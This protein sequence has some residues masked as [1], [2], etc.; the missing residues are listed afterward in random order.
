M[1]ENK[2]EF[3]KTARE[4][5]N[6]LVRVLDYIIDEGIPENR[7][8]GK[9]NVQCAWFR[10]FCKK[11]IDFYQSDKVVQFTEE[12]WEPSWQERFFTALLG[13]NHPVFADIDEEYFSKVCEKYVSVREGKV[14]RMYYIDGLILQEIGN[15]MG[16]TR[17]RI[18]QIL[19]LGLRKLRAPGPRNAL[20]YGGER[21]EIISELHTAQAEYDRLVTYREQAKKDDLAKI[22]ENAKEK[23]DDLNQKVEAIYKEL[24][25]GVDLNAVPLRDLGLSARAYNCLRYYFMD[26]GLPQTAASIVELDK[27]FKHVR[28]FGKAAAQ[29]VYDVMLSR[30]GVKV[31]NI[32]CDYALR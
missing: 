30:Y 8:C 25:N 9:E 19:N 21:S 31:T 4:K 5:A 17:E 20:V 11:D 27:D 6:R 22:V 12:D 23:A 28:N 29:E 10:W 1:K 16:Y 32:L 13:E 24:S 15:E 14:L 3:Y 18:R 7:A 26:N 2:L